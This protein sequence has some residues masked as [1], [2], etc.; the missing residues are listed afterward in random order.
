[1]EQTRICYDLV[2]LC[3]I[4]F[5]MHSLCLFW[6]V[7]IEKLSLC[8]KRT[9]HWNVFRLLITRWCYSD[10]KCFSDNK[11]KESALCGIGL[12]ELLF[13]QPSLNLI[14]MSSSADTF[15]IK[16]N[17]NKCGEDWLGSMLTRI[18]I[19]DVFVHSTLQLSGISSL[20]QNYKKTEN[21]LFGFSESHTFLWGSKIKLN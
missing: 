1:M 7:K 8:C 5:E 12:K 11:A 13:F 17:T 19:N 2:A 10:N 14:I 16:W 21:D 20:S 15:F 18:A 9:W 4:R 6:K 3:Y